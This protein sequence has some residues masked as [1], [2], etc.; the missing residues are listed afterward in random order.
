[1]QTIEAVPNISEGQRPLILEKL[2]ASVKQVKHVTLLDLSS[3]VSHNRS[4][5][6]LLGCPESVLQALTNLYSITTYQID[7]RTHRGVHPRI[8]AIDVVPFIP[9]RNASMDDC[10]QLSRQL[11]AEVASRFDI[12]IF[13]YEEAATQPERK[14]LENIRRGQ[15]EGLTQKMKDDRWAPDFGPLQPHPSAGASA[16][17]A[18]EPLIAFNVNL[19]TKNLT[20]ARQIAASIRARNGGLSHVKA[21]GFELPHRRLVQ[22]SVNL[23][24]YKITPLVRVFSTIE[25]EAKKLQV[26]VVDSEIVGLVPK[27]AISE[28]TI[29]RLRLKSFSSNKILE[30]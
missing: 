7:L 9:I 2:A 25:T 28:E 11:A 15:F 30:P 6:T 18:R 21:L 27:E 24:N 29:Q 12:P 10:K 20:I 4:V 14:A 26:E 23:T 3:D 8:G 16:I 13:L 1:M 5:L 17:G 22:V 19:K